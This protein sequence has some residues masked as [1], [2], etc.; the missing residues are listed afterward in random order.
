MEYGLVTIFDG[1]VHVGSG[2]LGRERGLVWPAHGACLV[3]LR[4]SG[5]P[6][7]ARNSSLARQLFGAVT[8]TKVAPQAPPGAERPRE[9]RWQVKSRKIES[10]PQND[11]HF[12]TYLGDF[13][14]V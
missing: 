7:T 4:L 5:L 2:V 12:A 10:G 3:C 8:V 6:V 11:F 1:V 13:Y 9:T 14:A